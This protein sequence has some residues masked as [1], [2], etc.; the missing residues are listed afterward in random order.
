MEMEIGY[1]IQLVRQCVNEATSIGYTK[2]ND[3]K[4]GWVV[5]FNVQNTTTK[6]E[7]K[8]YEGET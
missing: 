2:L 5:T 7:S 3:D 6:V 1:D 8:K 4:H